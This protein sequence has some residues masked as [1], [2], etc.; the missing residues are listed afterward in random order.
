MARLFA[1]CGLSFSGKTTLA[2]AIS[3][4]L[5]A[6]YLSLDDINEER[7]LYGGEGISGEEWNE[8]SLIAVERLGAL[9]AA[10]RDVVLDDTLSFRWLRERYRA[11]A[12]RH[13]AQFVLIYVATPLPEIRA[14]MTQ[15]DLSR[16]RR[17]IAPE[18]FAD[19]ASKFEVPDPDEQP[20]T[21]TRH[22]TVKEWLARQLS[23][24][25]R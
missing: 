19:H 13:A 9:L 11:V 12:Q 1:L 2:R 5:A 15:N 21:Y 3:T 20:L 4:L 7:G 16:Q 10:G 25:A 8:T 6:E 17:R 18:V 14:A 22:M 24:Q 23:Q